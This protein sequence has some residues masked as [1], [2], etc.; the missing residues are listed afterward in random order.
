MLARILGLLAECSVQLPECV[1]HWPTLKAICAASTR[2]ISH[3]RF[4]FGSFRFTSSGLYVYGDHC[5]ALSATCTP[6]ELITHPVT[7]HSDCYTPPCPALSVQLNVQLT[8]MH[9]L[10]LAS[11][12]SD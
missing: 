2:G 12:F 9:C 5:M 4:L 3:R 7:L 8:G 1:K 6:C 10:M 11:P